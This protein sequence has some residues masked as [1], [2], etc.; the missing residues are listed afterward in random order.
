VTPHPMQITPK[1]FGYDNGWWFSNKFL[2]R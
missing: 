2:W 1:T